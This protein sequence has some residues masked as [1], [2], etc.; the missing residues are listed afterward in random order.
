MMNV[1]FQTSLHESGDASWVTGRFGNLNA[2]IGSYE[3]Y[4]DQL[5][6]VKSFFAC[7]VLLRDQE[8]SDAL[9]E[10]IK[11]L[12]SFEN[13]LPYEPAGWDGSGDKKKIVE[14]RTAHTEFPACTLM[15]FVTVQ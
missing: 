11:G 5:Y 12:Q 14:I 6:G 15:I 1:V 8:Q 7:N 9:R 13:S 2:E 3:T 4:D 10:A